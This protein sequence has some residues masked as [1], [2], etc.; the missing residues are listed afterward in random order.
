MIFILDNGHGKNTAG[1]R[2]PRLPDGTIFY[3]WEFNR[4]VVKRI[5]E[6]CHK[7]GIRYLVLVPENEDIS[8]KERV[9]RVNAIKDECILISVHVN[10]STMEGLWGLAEGWSI[11]TSK[12]KT[13][14]D[15]YATIFFNEAKNELGNEY[16]MRTD[17]SDSDVDWEEDFYVLKNT[18]C[19]AV[20]TENLFMDNLKECQFLSSDKGVECIAQLHFK[21]IKKIANK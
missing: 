14:S 9:K 18:S 17:M 3:E 2:S 10:A 21:A 4:K 1:K 5:A 15:D 19:P 11:Y 8:L 7:E 6:L 20:L 16:K 13:K 12:G